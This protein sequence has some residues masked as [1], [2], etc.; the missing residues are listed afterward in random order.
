MDKKA[1]EDALVASL[2]SAFVVS[3]QANDPNRPHPRFSRYKC[4][5]EDHQELRRSRML[6]HQK[7]RRDDFLAIARSLVAGK[8]EADSD[9]EEIDEEM[10]D[11]SVYFAKKFRL[12]RTYKNQLMLS[13][14]LVDVPK[15]LADNWVMI[16][17][18]VGKRSLVVAG[19][20]QTKHYS[21]GGKFINQF[22]S[23]LPGGCRHQHGFRK[24]M[25]LLD[26]IFCPATNTYYV[27]DLMV[28]NDH[29]YYGCE[30]DFRR[31]WL[32][33]KFT[34]DVPEVAIKDKYN[35]YKFVILPDFSCTDAS[36]SKVLATED[37]LG[38][39]PLELDGLLFYHRQVQY[40]PGHTPLVGWLKGY[41]VPEMLGIAVAQKLQNQRPNNYASMQ[42]YVKEYTENTKRLADQFHQRKRKGM[43]VDDAKVQDVKEEET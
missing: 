23:A 15:D 39:G 42:G 3:N 28:W 29:Q 36:L 12:K 6:D 7:R 1:E 37:G 34:E 38:L 43:E 40:L 21:K 13:E 32:K 2:E 26:C 19:D 24:A 18:P 14:W 4:K 30:M 35:P 25:T 20:G 41:M 10:M 11:T 31:F 5:S 22:P 17:A 8:I 33:S 16:P 27:L 9:S